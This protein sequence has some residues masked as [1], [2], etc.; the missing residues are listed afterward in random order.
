MKNERQKL[1]LQLQSAVI[2]RG[3]PNV[4][5]AMSCGTGKI[6]MPVPGSLT[7]LGRGLILP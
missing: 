5:G 4:G 7:A 1:L 6:Q 2:R 3:K